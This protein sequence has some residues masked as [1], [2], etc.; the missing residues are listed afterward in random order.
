MSI[1]RFIIDLLSKHRHYF[2]VPHK[3]G[4]ELVRR[5]YDCGA[6]RA[7]NIKIDQTGEVV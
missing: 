1:F 6:V 7:V 2:G 4:G 5:C 3:E